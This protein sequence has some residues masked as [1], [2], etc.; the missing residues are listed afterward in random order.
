MSR[1]SKS[2]AREDRRQRASLVRFIVEH[3][4]EIVVKPDPRPG[5]RMMAT[6]GDYVTIGDTAAE[7]HSRALAHAM[8]DLRFNV[9]TVRAAAEKLV[10]L[11]L[12]AQVFRD[13][14]RTQGREGAKDCWGPENKQRG[15]F[16][17]PPRSGPPGLTIASQSGHAGIVFGG[18]PDGRDKVQYSYHGSRNHLRRRDMIGGWPGH[19]AREF[20]TIQ[21]EACEGRGR[22]ERLEAT[23]QGGTVDL[24]DGSFSRGYTATRTR[25]R[26]KPCRGKGRIPKP[27]WPSSAANGAALAQ[28]GRRILAAIDGQPSRCRQCGGGG[29]M[30]RLDVPEVGWFRPLD[31]DS[32]P[33]R[34]MTKTI[35]WTCESCNG[36]GHNL[37]GRLAPAEFT[38]QLLRRA[39]D[40]AVRELISTRG[41]ARNHPDWM[42]EIGLDRRLGVDFRATRTV[43]AEADAHRPLAVLREVERGLSLGA[44]GYIQVRRLESA[45]TRTKAQSQDVG[46]GGRPLRD[47]LRFIAARG[48]SFDVASPAMD[49]GDDDELAMGNFAVQYDAHVR[50]WIRQRWPAHE[51][52]EVLQA[53]RR[54]RIAERRQSRTFVAQ[55]QPANPGAARFDGVQRDVNFNSLHLH[56]RA[57]VA[58]ERTDLTA[59]EVA[60]LIFRHGG[61][62]PSRRDAGLTGHPTTPEWVSRDGIVSHRTAIPTRFEPEFITQ[63]RF[64]G[65]VQY[66]ERDELLRESSLSTATSA[67]SVQRIVDMLGSR[68]NLD[69]SLRD[70][71][72]QYTGL[73]SFEL[74]QTGPGEVTL[75]YRGDVDEDDLRAWLDD[76]RPMGTRLTLVKQG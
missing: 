18:G 11:E 46:P 60:D 70:L 25:E 61:I 64:G 72:S 29:R 63:Q 27:G 8:R 47:Q 1:A 5:Y 75:T 34:G 9:A 41:R 54:R 20:G 55:T 22:I 38:P 31:A 57:L 52:G 39:R 50:E 65:V 51:R 3:G 14:T 7:A 35:K 36:T 53:E 66:P 13:W 17:K 62:G 59:A 2:H 28:F 23:E 69:P 24:G 32:P 16:V 12:P 76:V 6:V 49:D 58:D 40:S 71:A 44:R 10:A 37:A 68:A 43:Y 56:N 74:I 42:R 33:S 48:E 45:E 26:C 73:E 67:E 15:A 21:C 19:L 4:V 30:A